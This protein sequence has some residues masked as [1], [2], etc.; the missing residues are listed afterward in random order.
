MANF[1]KLVSIQEM[2]W[3]D[4]G[5]AYHWT[6]CLHTHVGIKPTKFKLSCTKENKFDHF[7]L[8]FENKICVRK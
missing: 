4:K 1:N 8:N 2:L 3:I 5:C 7:F 6:D